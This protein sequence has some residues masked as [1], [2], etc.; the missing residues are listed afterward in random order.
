MKKLILAICIVFF[1]VGITPNMQAGVSNSVEQYSLTPGSQK[2]KLKVAKKQLK[3]LRKEFRTEMKGMNRVE[4]KAFIQDKIKKNQISGNIRYL[5][6]A[7]VCFLISGIAWVLPPIL[8]WLVSAVFGI[9]GIVF[10]VIWILNIL[11]YS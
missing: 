3:E 6:L 9:L 8:D 7:L 11:Q 10:L 2:E 1:A 4:K 5:V